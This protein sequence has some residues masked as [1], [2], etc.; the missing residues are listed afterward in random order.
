MTEYLTYYQDIPAPAATPAGVP[1]E[2]PAESPDP[3]PSPATGPSGNDE[4]SHGD[5]DEDHDGDDS[6]GLPTTGAP[7]AT[8]P[9]TRPTAPPTTPAPSSV[10]TYN[11]GDAGTVT[12]DIRGDTMSIVSTSPAN[13]WTARIERSSGQ[14][15]KVKFDGPGGEVKWKAHVENGRVD[16][17]IEYE[18]EG[19][20]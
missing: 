11:A 10:I 2:G 13:G 1:A 14:E 7:V 8:S 15:V 5:G 20:D 17:E 12:A 19:D 16:V 9:T 18:N 6:D 3:E 4:P